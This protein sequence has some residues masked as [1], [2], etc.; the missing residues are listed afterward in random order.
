M[1]EATT[2][3]RPAVRSK[4]SKTRK[5]EE[6]RKQI[7]EA[8]KRVLAKEGCMRFQLRNVAIEA[9]LSLSNVQYYFPTKEELV[10]GLM[11]NIAEFYLQEAEELRG[12]D[13]ETPIDRFLAMMDYLVN[14]I[15]DPEERYFW[16]Q[17]WAFVGASDPD[18]NKYLSEMYLTDIANIKNVLQDINP[19]LTKG[20]VQQRSTMIAAMVE[21]MM[22]M[23]D[24]ADV[25][26]KENE[27]SI[28]IQLKK[29]ALRIAMDP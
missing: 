18:K 21:G 14:M 5:G 4:H 12:C 8:C 16:I 23:F 11:D 13:T 29:Q 10:R 22:L 3:T 27:E 6:R 28:A 24:D 1:T 19:L 2:L 26:L 15:K 7:L 9:G 17:L 25:D 20:V